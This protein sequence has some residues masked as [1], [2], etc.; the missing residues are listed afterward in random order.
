MGTEA[1]GHKS[2]LSGITH[3]PELEHPQRRPFKLTAEPTDA[4]AS[5]GR[6]RKLAAAPLTASA[7]ASPDVSQE[8]PLPLVPSSGAGTT[9]LRWS[10]SGPPRE[11]GRDWGGGPLGLQGLRLL[12]PISPPAG[13]GV[14]PVCDTVSTDMCAHTACFCSTEHSSSFRVLLKHQGHRSLRAIAGL[15]GQDPRVTESGG[16]LN[17]GPQG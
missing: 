9:H 13:D 16:Y 17:S 11:R 7:F 10:P 14:S 5:R 1:S 15:Q 4:G 6:D 8:R 3:E 12:M 2:V